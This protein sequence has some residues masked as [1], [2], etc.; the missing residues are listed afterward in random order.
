MVWRMM[1]LVGVG[2]LYWEKEVQVYGKYD[3]RLL[4]EITRR[5]FSLLPVEV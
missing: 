5:L 2:H 1:I 3:E 4:R